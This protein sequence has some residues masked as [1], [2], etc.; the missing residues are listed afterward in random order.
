MAVYTPVDRQTIEHLLTRY[1]IGT[2]VGFQGI[3][4]GVENT[5]Y[6]LNVHSPTTEQQKTYV[7]TLFEYLPMP[8]LDF[9]ISVMETLSKQALPVPKVIWD[10]QGTALHSIHDKPAL[11]V[12]ALPGNHTPD[13]STTH[14]EQV[15]FLLAKM[16][17]TSRHHPLKQKSIRGLPWIKAQQER[18]SQLISK[19]DESLMKK[20]WQLIHKELPPVDKLPCGIIH[21]DLFFDNVLFQ[22]N[23]ITGVIDFYNA[24]YDWLAYDVAI[25]V[26][27]WCINPDL[28][29]HPE[30]Y[31]ALISAYNKVRPFT[32]KEKQYWVTLLQLAAFRFWLSRLVT[33]FFPES[34]SCGNTTHPPMVKSKD[35]DEFKKMFVLRY[36]EKIPEMR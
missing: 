18:L 21:G 23:T 19:N 3:E 2:L 36:Q 10:Q 4:S 11:I 13:I 12:T 17:R 31:E 35:P 27:D 8:A 7:L 28:T 30:K 34:N 25:T 24:G 29:I 15:G 20:G 32:A 5:N 26:N 33:F 9:Y 14:C 22:G 6:F 16:H 1:D